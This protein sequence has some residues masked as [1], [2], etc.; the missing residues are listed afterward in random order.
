MLISQR[1]FTRWK[2]H[3]TTI[4]IKLW[5]INNTQAS[6]QA[7][8]P[9]SFPK[10]SAILV[11]KLCISFC[12]FLNLMQTKSSLSVFCF[13]PFTHWCAFAI[14]S[15]WCMWKNFIIWIDHNLFICLKI[16]TGLSDSVI[17]LCLKIITEW[18]F[19]ETCSD[20]SVIWLSYGS[21]YR[22]AFNINS[23]SWQ[24]RI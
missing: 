19:K 1:I 20:V 7:L 21:S 6:F 15:C 8:I 2:C 23:S 5:N 17:S 16:K 11:S 14:H 22:I 4:Q 13:W 12:M 18:S 10:E 9:P 3:V 24:S